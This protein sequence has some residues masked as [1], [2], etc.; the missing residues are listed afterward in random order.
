MTRDECMEWSYRMYR[1][2]GRMAGRVISYE[3]TAK[4]VCPPTW[5]TVI[6]GHLSPRFVVLTNGVFGGAGLTAG[7][8][9]GLIYCK[10]LLDRLVQ[11][12]AEIT[13]NESASIPVVALASDRVAAELKDY[14]MP[15]W[16]QRALAVCAGLRGGYVFEWDELTVERAIRELRPHYWVKGGDRTLE[17]LDQGERE[18]AEEVGAEIVLVEELPLPHVSQ[19]RRE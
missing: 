17:T 4:R 18:A 16:E 14:P 15:L 10:P 12:F 9:W 13:S 1:T 3:E 7:Q 6:A 2:S 5:G 8:A 19:L 11:T